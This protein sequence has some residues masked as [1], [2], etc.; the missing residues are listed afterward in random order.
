MSATVLG[1]IAWKKDVDDEGYSVYKLRNLIKT[2]DPEDGP[3]TVM[4]AAGLPTTG[5]YWNYGNDSD[6]SA[7]CYPT[8]SVAPVYDVEKCIY[9][10]S[11]NT[12]SS[13]PL[14]KDASGGGGGGGGGDGTVISI[15]GSFTQA[16]KKT[17]KCIDPDNPLAFTTIRSSSHETIE[18]EKE[19][20]RPTVEIEQN[21]VDLGPGGFGQMVLMINTLN[22]APLWGLPER[23]IMLKNI[24]W[25]RNLYDPVNVYKR[26]ISF[27]ARWPGLQDS[28]DLDDILDCGWKVLR[29]KWV[30]NDWVVDGDADVANPMDFIIF[31][32][33]WGERFSEKAALIDG[34]PLTDPTNPQFLPTV[35]LY[36][37]SNFLLLGI[38]TTL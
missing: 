30:G 38:P 7:Y 1:R 6:F 2:T 8:M 22:D 14:S 13:K 37:T 11:E 18:V 26:T 28:W 9:W 4:N 33:K 25:S 36:T 17:S 5:S 32:D 10:I 34:V 31:K 21:V 27:E 15:S 19:I 12:F 23:S 29:G 35:K 3:D 24:Q 16:T 20:D